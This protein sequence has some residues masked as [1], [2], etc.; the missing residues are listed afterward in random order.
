V[1]VAT[2]DRSLIEYVGAR[3]IHLEFG[4]VVEG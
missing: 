1:V 3:S 2:H 4:Q